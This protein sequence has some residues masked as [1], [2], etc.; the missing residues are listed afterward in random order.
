[1]EIQSKHLVAE[2]YAVNLE[3]NTE[4]RGRGRAEGRSGNASRGDAVSI[5]KDAML[6]TEARRAAQNAPD[7]R[8]EKVEEL[9]SQVESGTYKADSRRTAAGLVREEPGLFRP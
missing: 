4:V 2:H 6:L 7:V 1:M 8:A 5:S 9:R 3:Q